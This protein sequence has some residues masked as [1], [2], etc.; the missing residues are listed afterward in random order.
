MSQ[1]VIVIGAGFTGVCIAENLRRSGASVTLLDRVKPGDTAQASYGNAGLLARAAIVPAMEPDIL[2]KLPKYLFS[3]KSPLN[4]RWSYLPKFLPFGLS[5][6]RNASP[7]R[8]RKISRSL[9]MLAH[10]TVEQH[11]NLAKGT[12][13]EKYITSST[14]TYLYPRKKDFEANRFSNALL[15]ELGIIPDWLNL[16]ELKEIDPALGDAYQFGARYKDNGYIS[17][18]AAYLH[19]L[20]AHFEANGGKFILGAAKGVD[21]RSI[22]LQDGTAL[23]ADT[24]VIAAGAWSKTLTASLGHKVPL[25][26]ERGY[27]LMLKSPNF[28]PPVPYLVTDAKYGMTPMD[29]GIRCAGTT[30]FAPLDSHRS[31]RPLGLLRDSIRRLYPTLTWDREETWMGHRPSTPD[32][33]PMLGRTKSNPSVIFAFGSQHLGLTIGP[34]LGVLAAQIAQNRS[35]NADISALAVDRFD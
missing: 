9:D 7:S 1:S 18:P 29:H 4:L 10:D 11:Q 20:T 8:V 25:E 23:S 27:H 22:T 21:G 15:A 17:D 24:I 35:P 5:F 28:T 33:L 3:R 6:L 31:E 19:A 34:K 26:G 14:L 2:P 30:E 32:S 13:A 16:Q 12:P